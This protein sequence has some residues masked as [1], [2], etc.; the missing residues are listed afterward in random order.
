MHL[1]CYMITLAESAEDAKTE[2]EIWLEDHAGR[3][4]YDYAD[5]EEPANVV[6]V[7]QV[8]QEL[9]ELKAEK[10]KLLPVIEAE[11]DGYKKAGNRGM[12]GYA[13][14]RYGAVLDEDPSYDMPF[15]NLS[16]W[17][18]SIPTEV[19]KGDGIPENSDWYAV[20]VDFHF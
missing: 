7:S 20:M 10:E 16:N 12:E 8:R 15:F 19:P 9:E 3:E 11:I 17:D 2:V 1:H 4:F 18:W 14:K 13:H 6:L 5:L